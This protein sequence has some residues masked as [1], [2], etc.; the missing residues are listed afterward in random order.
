MQYAQKLPKLLKATRIALLLIFVF[1]AP[2]APVGKYKERSL[3]TK[4][5]PTTPTLITDKRRPG[6]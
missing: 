6:Y 4:T 5:N 3:T 2:S 1:V